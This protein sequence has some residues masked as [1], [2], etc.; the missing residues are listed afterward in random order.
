MRL[1]LQKQVISTDSVGKERDLQCAGQ[2]TVSKA[3][4]AMQALWKAYFQRNK[5]QPCNKISNQLTQFLR[6]GTSNDISEINLYFIKRKGG[7]GRVHLQVSKQSTEILGTCLYQACICVRYHILHTCG[8]VSTTWQALVINRSTNLF[9]LISA[10]VC[11]EDFITPDL[12][13]VTE[14]VCHDLGFN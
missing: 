13:L 7:S 6:D 9:P 14:W 1:F 2:Q 12:K 4:I 10:A 3:I 11:G 8:I 5:T